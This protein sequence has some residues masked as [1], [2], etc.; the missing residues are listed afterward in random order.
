MR[1]IAIALVVAAIATGTTCQ[2]AWSK[3]DPDAET[4][5]YVHQACPPNGMQCCFPTRA[6][7]STRGVGPLLAGAGTIAIATFGIALVLSISIDDRRKLAQQEL[8]RL[9]RARVIA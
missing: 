3:L 5:T 6:V 1:H 4:V 2:L 9:A 8:D 7:T